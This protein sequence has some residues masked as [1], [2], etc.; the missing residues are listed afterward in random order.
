M[1]PA[2]AAHFPIAARAA[3]CL[4]LALVASCGGGGVVGSGGTGAPNTA[5]SVGTVNGFGSVIVDGASFDDRN[6]VVVAE[7]APGVDSPAEVRL[8]ERVSVAYTKAGVASEIRI[9]PALSGPVAAAP[10]SGRFTMLGQTVVVNAAGG[11][12]P[13]TQFGGGYLRATDI[14]A[15]DAIDVHGVLVLQGG[16]WVISATRIDKLAAAPAYLRVTGVVAG[17]V[18][19]AR[20][21]TLGALAVDA[22]AAV[23]VPDAASLV[24]GQ[25]V[26][27]LAS[28]AAYVATGA[29]APRL[30]AAQV[31]IAALPASSLDDTLSGSVSS[32]DT[33]AKTFL[34]GAQRVSYAGAAISPAGASLS[35]GSYVQVQGRV[36]GDGTLVATAVNVRAGETEDEADLSGTIV[37]FD[38]VA[39]AF[40]LRDVLV[41]AS[42]AALQGCPVGGL[43]N[44]LYVQVAGALASNGV[45]AATIQCQS[46]PAGGTV[47]RQGRASGVDTV[48]TTFTLT[49]GTGAPITVQ[50]TGTTYFGSGLAPATLSGKTVDVQGSF[51]GAVLVAT[52]V[53]LDD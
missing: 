6:A 14:A 7:A 30:Q 22:G 49:P 39:K 41:D 35:N 3:A 11:S 28:P 18:A 52:K 10:S 4:A 43:A 16:S 33:G 2:F 31:R 27:L 32:L 45:T 17:F 48:A 37:A 25:P 26:T 1:T 38:P 8:G 29:G 36:G 23:F 34:L 5:Y 47:E 40:T 51:A 13:T 24:N 12:G 42:M 46:E 50:W 20:T 44:G 15:G 9:L 53:K 19:A 21:F